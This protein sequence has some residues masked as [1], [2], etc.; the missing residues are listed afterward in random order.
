[1]GKQVILVAVTAAKIPF[2]KP[3]KRRGSN[4]PLAACL[5]RR[6][7]DDLDKEAKKLWDKVGLLFLTQ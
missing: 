2:T 4:P 1:M 7:R 5:A 6:K 3:P